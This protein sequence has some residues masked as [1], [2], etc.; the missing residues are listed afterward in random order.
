MGRCPPTGCILPTYS[1]PYFDL[2]TLTRVLGSD[3][4][5]GVHLLGGVQGGSEDCGGD[6]TQFPYFRLLWT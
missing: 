3:G 1:R 6:P 4:Y 5:V 2:E